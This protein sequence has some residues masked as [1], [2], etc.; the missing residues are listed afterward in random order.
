MPYLKH[1]LGL[2]ESKL[3]AQTKAVSK[4][5]LFSIALWITKSIKVV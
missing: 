2:V 5:T 3:K 1:Q 4:N